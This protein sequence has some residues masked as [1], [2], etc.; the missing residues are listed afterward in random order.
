MSV[1]VCGEIVL[2]CHP[3]IEVLELSYSVCVRAKDILC[4]NALTAL[5]L[6]PAR[7]Y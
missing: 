2:D 1:K 3:D 5:G 7:D 4:G 6:V